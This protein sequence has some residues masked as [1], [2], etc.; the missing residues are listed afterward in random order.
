M[1]G[2]KRFTD[3][4]IRALKPKASRYTVAEGEGFGL[5][6]WPNGT[7]SWVLRYTAPDGRRRPMTL[8]QY[9]QTSLQEARA[10]AVV[11][12][13]ALHAGADPLDQRKATIEAKMTAAE[14]RRR[15]PTLKQAF[16][17]Y[18]AV[19][20]PRLKRARN[21]EEPI[22][23]NVLPELGETK[24]RDLRRRDLVAVLDVMLA[25]GALHYAEQT[26]SKL[27]TFFGWCVD[28]EL[29]EANPLVGLK[30][31]AKAT[32]R[33]RALSDAEI[34]ILWEWLGAGG[35]VSTSMRDAL[36][37]VLLTGQRPGE[38][39]GLTWQEIDQTAA[40][41][42]LPAAR[43][44]NGR[45][46]AVPLAPAVL[47]ILETRRAMVRGE[48]VFPGKRGFAHIITNSV[49][50]MLARAL[51][52]AGPRGLEPFRPHDLRRTCRTGLARLGIP[53]EVGERVLN[54]APG[55][56]LA[57]YNAHRYET[58]KRRA[59]EAW[60]VHVLELSG[61]RVPQASKVV[62]LRR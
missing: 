18:M 37:L 35:L 8:G 44:K 23:A 59:L 62:T 17:D 49:D 43:T 55:G 57:V 56:V 30:P 28:R 22:R 53:D 3:A 20:G 25:R 12:R 33:D 45:A 1:T 52:E 48:H 13:E 42:R 2:S 15:A 41:W 6:V 19:Q 46:H 61:E 11:A 31:L 58:E 4:Y 39:L 10:K 54:H 24:L 27:S 21:I 47:A 38:V 5:M 36:R 26:R 29:I 51:A 34:P 50:S 7:K 9:P 14:E 16:A 40:L 60:A 32:P